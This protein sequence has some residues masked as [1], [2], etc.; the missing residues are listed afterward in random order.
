M[1]EF[2]ESD[3]ES[4]DVRRGG[5]SDFRHTAISV[6]FTSPIAGP[7][8]VTDLREAVAVLGE[9]PQVG[10]GWGIELD[11][12]SYTVTMT[13]SERAVQTEPVLGLALGKRTFCE[14]C[15]THYPDLARHDYERHGMDPATLTE[16]KNPAGYRSPGSTAG[17]LPVRQELLG[18]P[19]DERLSAPIEWLDL[20]VRAFNVCKR[21]GLHTVADL[22]SRYSAAELVEL[23]NFGQR[24]VDELRGKLAQ[25][26]LKLRGE[27]AQMDLIVVDPRIQDHPNC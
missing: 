16:G 2:V 21:E 3:Y 11:K 25:L 18:V 27:D 1:S 10:A 7:L 8:T 17:E 6:D 4:T 9:L 5:H 22:V 24:G 26:G 12:R 15:R 14:V 20:T 23:R 19:A 13:V